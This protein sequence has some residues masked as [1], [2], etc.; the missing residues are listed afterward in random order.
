MPWN[1]NIAKAPVDPN[2]DNLIASIGLTTGLHPDFGKGT[3][4]GALIGIPYV[5]VSG[6]QALVPIKFTQYGSQ[7]D[8]GPY[9][10]PTNAP[11][12]GYRPD[13]KVVRRRSPCACDRQ[14]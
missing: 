3:Y 7:S 10:V 13:G 12:E 11:I 1:T 2:S 4:G 8:A 5:V 9:P 6:S 14:G